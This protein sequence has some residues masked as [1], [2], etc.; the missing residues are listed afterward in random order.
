MKPY[1][2]LEYDRAGMARVD[3]SRD[4]GLQMVHA[5]DDI[6]AR[7]ELLRRYI[8]TLSCFFARPAIPLG[9]NAAVSRGGTVMKPSYARV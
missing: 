1:D 5:P 9:L 2:R 8:A 3:G 4:A 7:I 6:V